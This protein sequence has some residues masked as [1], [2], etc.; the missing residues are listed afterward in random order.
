MARAPDQG[1][2]EAPRG[3]DASV[4]TTLAR[5]TGRPRGYFAVD[6]VRVPATTTI[7]S[8]FKESGGLLYWA[9]T[10]GLEGKT[11]EEAR[12]TATGTGHLVHSMVEAKIHGQPLPKVNSLDAI[13]SYQA[14]LEWWEGSKL[15]VEATEIALVSEEHRFG[16][17]IDGILRDAKGRLALGDWKTSAGIYVDY[18]L[19]IAAY[20]LLWDEVNDEKLTGGFHI[21]RFSKDHG[22]LEHRHFSHLD[23]AR[24]MFIL[25]RQA[26][27]LDKSVKKRAK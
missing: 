10:Q 23:D 5:G 12:E 20:G 6:G 18:L 8:R 19:Q 9:N 13:S 25:L 3:E 21:V 4:S 27:E 17:T 22:D 16:G 1:S 14:W 11:L 26:Y 15:T 2:A 24:E 7:L